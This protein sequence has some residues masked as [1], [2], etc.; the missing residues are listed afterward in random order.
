MISLG[1]DLSTKTGYAILK[2]G[3]LETYGKV[4]A[5]DSKHIPLEYGMI[6]QAKSIAS[7][8]VLLVEKWSPQ[9]ICIE[10]TN[11][12]RSRTTQKKLEFIHYAVLDSLPEQFK[13]KVVYIDTSAWRSTLNINFS[14]DQRNHN[15]FMS[16]ERRINIIKN[17]PVPSKQDVIKLNKLQKDFDKIKNSKLT[18][19][20]GKINAKH[21]A[22]EYINA[23]YS[24]KLKFKDN[25]EA[26][27]ICLA[28]MGILKLMQDTN[29][30]SVDLNTVFN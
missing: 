17:N 30:F 6:F 2:D 13:S 28:E 1:L 25:D 4:F 5:K 11:L 9:V 15:K 7:E 26:D 10:Q 21:L 18:L 22:V 3:K 27:A 12:G 24:L 20:R 23:K 29:N 8:I 16:L 14:K 19:S